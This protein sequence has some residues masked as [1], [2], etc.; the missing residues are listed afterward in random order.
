MSEDSPESLPAIRAEFQA[1]AALLERSPDKAGRDAIKRRIIRLFKS[2]DATL[3]DLAKLKEDIRSLVNR[4]KQLS[5]L[6]GGAQLRS[7]HLGASTYVEKAWSLLSAGEAEAAIQAL[8]R[9]LELSPG[10]TQAEAMLGWAELQSGREVEALATFS[11]V[12]KQE[13]SNALARMNVGYL[14]LKKRSFGE[15]I[16]QLSRVIQLDS[17]P[18]ATLY[19]HYYLGLVYFERGMLADAQSFL[20]KAI[21]L[22]PNLIEAYHD[23]GRAQWLAGQPEAARASWTRGAQAGRV[24]PWSRRCQELLDRVAR[25]EEVPRSSS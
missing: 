14:C 20:T 19:A 15:A 12:L 23:L 17:D 2:V 1:I 6:G 24:S 9:A 10:N 8:G 22:G 18:K 7:D 13:P 25:G 16:E 11:R 21:A 5:A 4:Y 3:A